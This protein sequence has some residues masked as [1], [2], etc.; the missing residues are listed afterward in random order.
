MAGENVVE[1]KKPEGEVVES[2]KPKADRVE[3]E[4]LKELQALYLRVEEA[5]K[6]YGI[7]A[8]TLE[9]FCK[10]VL[11]TY[12]V[13]ADYTINIRT[14]AFERV[15]KPDAAGAAPSGEGAKS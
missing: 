5:R 6:A 7:R 2:A 9:G 12:E 14:G 8:G 15:K 13:P 1:L 4:L 11:E 3:G 10:R